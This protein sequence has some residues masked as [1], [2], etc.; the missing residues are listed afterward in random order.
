M[1]IKQ[2]TFSNRKKALR[3]GQRLTE[4]GYGICATGFDGR[5][6]RVLFIRP[7]DIQ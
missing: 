5:P 1:R 4:L 7:K 3:F 2:T 6:Y